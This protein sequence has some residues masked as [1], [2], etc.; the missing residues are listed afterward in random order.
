MNWTLRTPASIWDQPG[1]LPG[2]PLA[3]QLS[4]S[5]GSPLLA[6]KRAG[7]WTRTVTPEQILRSFN[8]R[9]F[10]REKPEK[11]ELMLEFVTQAQARRAPISFVEYWGKGLRLDAGER[12]NLPAWIFFNS[13]MSRIGEIY[14][15]GA[16]F[17]LVFTDT[18]AALNGHSQASIFRTLRSGT[19]SASPPVQ[20]LPAQQLVNAAGLRPD[21]RRNSRFHRRVLAELRPSAAKLFKG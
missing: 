12:R 5:A 1:S 13:M 10:K 16:D 18:H 20:H 17:T 7:A 8:T 11:P 15:P 14:E 19:R 2:H 6:I 21:E 3:H 9:A 4:N